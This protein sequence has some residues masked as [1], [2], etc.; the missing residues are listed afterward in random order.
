MSA[1]TAIQYKVTEKH[2]SILQTESTCGRVRMRVQEQ[3]T[4]TGRFRPSGLD[5]GSTTSE[6]QCLC[7]LFK[8]APTLPQ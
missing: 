6:R 4:H 3:N 5:F 1:H 7:T 8:A 2:D